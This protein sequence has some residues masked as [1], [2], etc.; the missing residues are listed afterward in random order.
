MPNEVWKLKFY[1]MEEL[2]CSQNFLT[3]F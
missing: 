1:K 2:G 3:K